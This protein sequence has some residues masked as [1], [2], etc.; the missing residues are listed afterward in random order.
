MKRVFLPCCLFCLLLLP[1]LARADQARF[2]SVI[3][4]DSLMIR[5]GDR[6]VE[7]RLI[8]VDAPE[9]DQEWGVRAKAFSLQFCY[10][11]ELRLEYDKER[12]DRYGRLLAYVY[13]GTTML[14]EALVKNGLAVPILVRPNGRYYRKFKKAGK[15]AREERRGFWLHGGLSMTPGQWRKKHRKS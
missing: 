4:G 7:V 10:G 6:P 1:A 11:K 2:L 12:K 5:L 13:D 3:D 8:G 9:W 14:N 15:T